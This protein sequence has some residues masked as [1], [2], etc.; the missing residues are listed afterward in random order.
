MDTAGSVKRTLLRSKLIERLKMASLITKRIANVLE[1]GIIEI[2]I[3]GREY[4]SEEQSKVKNKVKT[5]KFLTLYL[6]NYIGG[7]RF[8][9]FKELSSY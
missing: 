4:W 5:I 1:R 8:L 2:D 6:Q 9:R 3:E 7:H